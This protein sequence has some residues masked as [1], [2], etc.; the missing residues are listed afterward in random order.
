MPCKVRQTA[1]DGLSAIQLHRFTTPLS[2]E[3]RDTL[4]LCDQASM[5]AV[6][7]RIWSDT[8]RMWLSELGDALG[9]C[10]QV[11]LKICT[12]RLWWNELGDALEGYDRAKSEEYLEA[13]NLEAV[14]WE[15]GTTGAETLFIGEPVIVRM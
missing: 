11:S 13:S 4:Q 8:W 12:G 3:R 10:D 9:A 5:E 15:E 14:V 7:E 2:S 6:I 1:D